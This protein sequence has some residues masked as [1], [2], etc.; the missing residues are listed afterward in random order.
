GGR[1]RGDGRRAARGP[2]TG[3]SGAGGGRPARGGGARGRGRAGRRGRG[4]RRGRAARWG[5][6]PA[7]ERAA[8][9]R[10]GCGRGGGDGA[11]AR[12]LLDNGGD[13]AVGQIEAAVAIGVV[14]PPV[15]L[16]GPGH[17]EGPVLLVRLGPAAPGEA[18]PEDHASES[19][20]SARIA[21]I[22]SSVRPERMRS[23]GRRSPRLGF[24]PKSQARAAS[25][26]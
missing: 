21:R 4:S 14:V 23:I 12:E 5:P 25:L 13:L 6:R 3:W 8:R 24:T 9:A 15:A 20:R 11:E 18:A 16:E 26:S 2:G 17:P 7:G 22:S 1:R 10:R 19:A